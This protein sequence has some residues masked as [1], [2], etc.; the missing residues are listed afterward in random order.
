MQYFLWKSSFQFKS[1]A[2]VAIYI[3]I[4]IVIMG[5]TLLEH[6]CQYN[7]HLVLYFSFRNVWDR[8]VKVV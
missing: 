1:M 3:I 2:K 8:V 6:N 7:V 5:V 4:N